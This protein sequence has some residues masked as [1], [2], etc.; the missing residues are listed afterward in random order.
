M[1]MLPE[2]VNLYMAVD[3]GARNI[4]DAKLIF[5][6]GKLPSRMLRAG[7]L[8]AVIASWSSSILAK[9]SALI[10]AE[11]QFSQILPLCLD[12][13]RK[14]RA[15]TNLAQQSFQNYEMQLKAISSQLPNF[16]QQADESIQEQ[17]AFCDNVRKTINYEIAKSLMRRATGICQKVETAFANNNLA[18]AE[19]LI[20]RYQLQKQNSLKIDPNVVA[21]AAIKAEIVHCDKRITRAKNWRTLIEKT[22]KLIRE[23]ASCNDLY[24]PLEREPKHDP[25]SLEKAK[26]QLLQTQGVLSRV[27]NQVEP[28]ITTGSGFSTQSI[29]SY[30]STV[31]Q[32]QGCIIGLQTV[33]DR[34]DSDSAQIIV[35]DNKDALHHESLVQKLKKRCAMLINAAS[36][37][38]LSKAEFES[39]GRAKAQ[40]II[41]LEQ[42]NPKKNQPINKALNTCAEDLEVAF[43]AAEATMLETTQPQKTGPK[44]TPSSDLL[45]PEPQESEPATEAP[46]PLLQRLQNL[47]FWR[48]K[49]PE[50]K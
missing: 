19:K 29:S 27:Q 38:T 45:A 7:V 24:V 3:T 30:E 25:A 20:D 6:G 33:L 35:T 48:K 22:S 34:A 40:F 18:E 44:I 36:M 37:E 21:F 14:R 16:K 23:Q 2:S 49:P 50:K 8:L 47:R 41:A 32:M 26:A 5:N 11:Y 9:S 31:E 10:N 12:A 17:L 4:A 39:L 28:L 42:L 46:L 43:V 1:N 13:N 15:E